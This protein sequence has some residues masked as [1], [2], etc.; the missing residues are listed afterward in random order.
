MSNHEPAEHHR[1]NGNGRGTNRQSTVENA[2]VPITKTDISVPLTS[3]VR[4]FAK[5]PEAFLGIAAHAIEQVATPAEVL[6]I[7]AHLSVVKNLCRR[8]SKL[9]Q[10][11]VAVGILFQK[12]RR[13][14]GLTLDS[15]DKN[16]GALNRGRK[17]GIASNTLT[18]KDLNISKAES[19]RVQRDA[20]IPQQVFDTF[21][22]QCRDGQIQPTTAALEKFAKH[23]ADSARETFDVVRRGPDIVE[24]LWEL[25]AQEL[26][27]GTFYA[28]VPWPYTNTASRGAA[29]NHYPSMTLQQISELPVANLAADEAHLHLW[30]TSSFLREA[31]DVI[32]AW[33]FR[34]ASSCV[35]IKD[36]NDNLGCG[37]YYRIDHEF[38]LLGVR[39]RLTFPPEVGFSSWVE[40][41][42]LGHSRKPEEFR[43]RIYAVSPAPRIELFARAKLPIEGWTLV[44][45]EAPISFDA[46]SS[47]SKPE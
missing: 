9:K 6:T 24:S 21:L 38:L 45:N 30:V 37:N 5:D 14:L 25:V 2:L 23:E 46:N 12:C 47:T 1:H 32:D 42:R 39:G 44:G 31:F 16:R 10:H 3:S 43:D 18:L 29:A 33:G 27:F 40:L 8:F 35:W 19:S 13:Q 41:P 15:M 26:K 22:K 17:R 36:R 11:L 7:E 28:D 20:R 4:N 34:Y